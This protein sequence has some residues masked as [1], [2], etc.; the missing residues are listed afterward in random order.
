MKTLEHLRSSLDHL[1]KAHDSADL[2]T[3]M[4]IKPI[5]EKLERLVERTE[6][7]EDD[8]NE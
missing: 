3:R 7:I 1:Q 2:G 4:M 6:R 8:A 5:R